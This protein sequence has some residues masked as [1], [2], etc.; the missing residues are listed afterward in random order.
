MIL[1]DILVRNQ[2]GETVFGLKQS[3]FIVIEDG[4]PQEIELFSSPDKPSNLPRYFVLIIDHSNSH[5]DEHIR[6]SINAAKLFVDKLAPQDNMAIVNDDVKLKQDFTN[7]KK[8]LKNQL[9]SVYKSYQSPY[10]AASYGYT[11]T[12]LFTV[13]N[14]MFNE[15]GIR[16]IVVMQSVGRELD[17]LKDGKRDASRSEHGLYYG[18]HNFTFEDILR[19][20]VEKRA[21]VYSIITGR[22]FAGLSDKQKIENLV[23]MQMDYQYD[24]TPIKLESI[25]PLDK[26]TDN[27]FVRRIMQESLEYQ[28]ALIELAETSGGTVNFLQTPEDAKTIYEDIFSSFNNRY[29][30]AYYSTNQEQT[31]KLRNVKIEVR[32]HPE[33]LIVGRKTYLPR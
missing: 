29:L 13:L 18:F 7:D 9:D 11:Y 30:I 12:A 15:E 25:V 2:K 32:E 28:S 10:R 17:M 1:N 33:Y 6:N 24:W 5:N 31:K 23:L 22:R 19:K 20:I 26:A 4:K 16:P 27:H 3:D 14:E 8:K 21:T